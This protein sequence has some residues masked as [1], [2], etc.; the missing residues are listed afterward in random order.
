MLNRCSLPN[1]RR[2]PALAATA[3]ATVV[4]SGFAFAQETTVEGVVVEG[5]AVPSPTPSHDD[6]RPKLNH[7]MREVE[8]TEITVT[9]KASVIK[10]DQQPP[11]QANNMQELFVKAP[12]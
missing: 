8:G 3:V 7:I 10:L 12:G 11:V 6:T 5:A 1:F 4:L 9:K 2:L